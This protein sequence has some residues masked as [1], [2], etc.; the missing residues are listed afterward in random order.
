MNR[1][2]LLLFLTYRK[3][4]MALSEFEIQKVNKLAEAFLAQ[5]RPPAHM[6]A[7]LDV[8]IK[9]DNQSVIVFEIRPVW[10]EPDEKQEVPIAKTTFVKSQGVWKIYW[11]RA[12]LKWHSYQPCPRVKH[13][14]AFFKVLKDDDHL[15]FWG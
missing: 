7:K 1:I 15:C 10:N 13:L 3:T 4:K 11:Q 2:P 8:G 6:R 5:I 14:E 12:D 9:L